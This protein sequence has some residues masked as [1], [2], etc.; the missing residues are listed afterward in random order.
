MKRFL[1]FVFSALTL[2]LLAGCQHEQLMPVQAPVEFASFKV[3]VGQTP[4]ATNAGDETKSLITIDSKDFKKAALYAFYMDGSVQK[5]LYTTTTERTFNWDLPLR[6]EMYIYCIMNYGDVNLPAGEATRNGLDN[7]MFEYGNR[8]MT[9][10]N[11]T[12]LPKAGITHIGAN[13]LQSNTDEVTVKVKNLFSKF[14][15]DLDKSSLKDGDLLDVESVVVYN[16][17]TSVHYFAPEGG[18]KLASYNGNPFDRA[19][20]DDLEKFTK[21]ASITLYVLE[22]M[23]GMHPTFGEDWNLMS[24]THASELSDA[25]YVSIGLRVKHD[26]FT[27]QYYHLDAYLNS[28]SSGSAFPSTTDFNIRRNVVRSE[29]LNWDYRLGTFSFDER[30]YNTRRNKSITIPFEFHNYDYRQVNVSCTYKDERFRY[31]VDITPDPDNYYNGKGAIYVYGMPYDEDKFTATFKVGDGYSNG[32]NAITELTVFEPYNIELIFTDDVT[33]EEVDEIE[34]GRP[35]TV[36][37]RLTDHSGEEVSLSETY[38]GY[39]EWYVDSGDHLDYLSL[40]DSGT[41]P[42]TGSDGWKRYAG[43]SSSRFDSEYSSYWNVGMTTGYEP[44]EIFVRFCEADANPIEYSSSILIKPHEVELT[45]NPVVSKDYGDGNYDIYFQISDALPFDIVVE[46][47]S[48]S[49]LHTIPAGSYVSTPSY[50]HLGDIVGFR[51]FAIRRGNYS[52]HDGAEYYYK[53]N[54]T[55][56]TFDLRAWGL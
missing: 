16:M 38:D 10:F 49:D 13:E 14:V 45:V 5:C 1:L 11:A 4:P 36:S 29:T 23:A 21:D 19:T 42:S 50:M 43:Y 22:N 27:Y 3:N 52:F 35:F 56:Y 32:Q 30:Y 51:V 33:G 25:T 8:Q 47:A 6:T 18:D 17:N 39:F 9:A 12:G 46:N 34:V 44:A 26:D 54:D 2:S 40:K 53:D 31:S 15:L 24:Q 55:L 28:N 48:N 37:A 7:L 20:A 41:N